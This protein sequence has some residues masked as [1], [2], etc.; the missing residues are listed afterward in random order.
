MYNIKVIMD[1][2]V[3]DLHDKIASELE[4]LESIFSEDNVI[5]EGARQSSNSD[6]ES[7]L[8]LTPNTGF[9]SEKIA[10]IVHARFHFQNTVRLRCAKT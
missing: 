3:Q 10:V 8:R 7:T 2:P 1:S 9:Q 5:A 4:M 6:I